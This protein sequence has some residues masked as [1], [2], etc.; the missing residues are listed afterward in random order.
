PTPPPSTASPPP[1]ASASGTSSGTQLT[2]QSTNL[3]RQ[4]RYQEALPVA[5]QAL[6]KL[7]GSGQLYEAYANYNVGRSLIELGRC[8]EGLPY[9]A[10]SERIQGSR[11]EFREAR[12]KC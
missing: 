8:A 12:A 11:R 6:A 7:K 5:Q 4:G 10:A 2:D 1:P 9:I 3:M